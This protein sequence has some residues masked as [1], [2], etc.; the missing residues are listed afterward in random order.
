[1]KTVEAA[2]LVINFFA[3]LGG[4][5][6]AAATFIAVIRPERRR[7]KDEQAA[8]AAAVDLFASEL[9]TLRGL[10]GVDA[11]VLSSVTT[12]NNPEEVADLVRRM[13][14]SLSLPLIQATA[15]SLETALALNRLRSALEYWNRAIQAMSIKPEEITGAYYEFAISDIKETHASL[16]REIRAAARVL[17]LHLPHRRESLARIMV[18][19]DG[20]IVG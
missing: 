2:G 6:A 17:Y 12:D 3:G 1:M 16:L 7:R 8:V 4:W 15:D 11:L 10:L 9:V 14:H 13:S 19:H 20:Y 18:E 5:I